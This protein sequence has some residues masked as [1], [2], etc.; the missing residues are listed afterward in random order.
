MRRATWRPGRGRD[1]GVIAVAAVLLTAG[2]A[3][4][5]DIGRVKTVKGAVRIERQGREEP[6]QVGSGVQQGDRLV[7]GADGAVG[8]TLADETRLSAGPDTTL[9]LDRFAFEPRTQQGGLEAWLAR[10]TLAAV[11]GRLAKQG[12]AAMTIRMPSAVLGVRGTEL[13]VR[14]SGAP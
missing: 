4:A 9:V 1:A 10:G 5:Q 11:S 13:V 7:T 6:V 12:P 8:I 14:A 3:G 2:L